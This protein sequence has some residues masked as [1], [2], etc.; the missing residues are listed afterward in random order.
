MGMHGVGSGDETMHDNT[1]MG[2]MLPVTGGIPGIFR[3]IK[4]YTS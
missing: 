3:T 4:V 1:L 2:V